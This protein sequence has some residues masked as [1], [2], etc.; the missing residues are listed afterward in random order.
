MVHAYILTLSKNGALRDEDKYLMRQMEH[1]C[2]IMY[3]RDYE[4]KK[5]K[6]TIIFRFWNFTDIDRGEVSLRVSLRESLQY[7]A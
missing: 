6:I 5:K 4:Q 7:W 1:S 2:I 3:T